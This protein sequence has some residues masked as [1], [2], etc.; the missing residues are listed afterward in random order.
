MKLY[1]FATGLINL[2]AVVSRRC[3]T[4]IDTAGSLCDCLKCTDINEIP[5]INQTTRNQSEGTSIIKTAENTA[6]TQITAS[7]A[8]IKSAMA[9]STITRIKA[10][11]TTR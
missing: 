9:T 11:E 10:T 2:T 5:D 8:T 6:N 7:T 4:T 3:R 1:F